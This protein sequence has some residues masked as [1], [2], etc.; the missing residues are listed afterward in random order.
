[1]SGLNVSDV[2]PAADWSNW[3]ATRIGALVFNGLV[4]LVACSPSA[5][6]CCTTC[7]GESTCGII[8]RALGLGCLFGL[9]VHFI[10]CIWWTCDWGPHDGEGVRGGIWFVLWGIMSV[11]LIVTG[12]QQ[13]E[14]AKI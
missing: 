6:T 7:C 12:L 13:Q 2:W 8:A 10:P 5:R 14:H 11:Y 3:P 4:I 1:M 9:F